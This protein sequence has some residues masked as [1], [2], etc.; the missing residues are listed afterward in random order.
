M[1]SLSQLREEHRVAA[2]CHRDILSQIA[3]HDGQATAYQLHWL[4]RFGQ[5]IEQSIAAIARRGADP[6]E[7]GID[8]A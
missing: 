8:D 5:L 3:D 1:S 6:F 4:E 2:D 7:E